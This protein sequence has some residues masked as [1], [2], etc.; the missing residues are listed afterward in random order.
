MSDVEDQM[1]EYSKENEESLRPCVHCNAPWFTF[2]LDPEH[3][4]DCPMVTNI[5][6]VSLIDL[7]DDGIVCSKCDEPFHIG[8]FYKA[9]PQSEEIDVYVMVCVP[10]L[11]Y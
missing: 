2:S 1:R 11:N 5:F 8:G 10:C 6:P 7:E 4:A 3:K 9:V